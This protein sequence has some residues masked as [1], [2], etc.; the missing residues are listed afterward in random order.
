MARPNINDDVMERLKEVVN[1][2]YQ[3]DASMLTSQQKVEALL[4]LVDDDSGGST[5][6]TSRTTTP[7]SDATVNFDDKS[8]F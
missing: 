6:T 3:V 5:S 8:K 1:E 4:D 2:N 7:P